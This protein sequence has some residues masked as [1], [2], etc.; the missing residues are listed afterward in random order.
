MAAEAAAADLGREGAGALEC[1]TKAPRGKGA[2]GK[3]ARQGAVVGYGAVYVGQ[4]ASATG[5]PRVR[6]VIQPS[7]S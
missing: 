7:G 1:V 5:R 6:G 3:Y 2:R 4:G